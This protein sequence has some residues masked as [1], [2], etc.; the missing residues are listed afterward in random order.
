MARFS[1]GKFWSHNT[2]KS[3]SGTT[4]CFRNFLVSITFMYRRGGEYH[5]FLLENFC[6]TVWKNFVDE[7]FSA[8]FQK[9]SGGDKVYG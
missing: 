1:A 3:R 5:D 7:P 2:G 8:V 6:R 9:V 4:L